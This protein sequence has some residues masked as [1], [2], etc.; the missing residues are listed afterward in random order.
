VL[1][2]KVRAKH[3]PPA[4]T[5]MAPVRRG[6]V[7]EFDN[8]P[9]LAQ[10]LGL[11]LPE[12]LWFADVKGLQ[13]RAAAGKL[14]HYRYLWRTGRSGR[15]RLLEAPK[16]R[17]RQIQRTLLDGVLAPIG[18]SPAVHGFV[19]GRS[20]VTAARAHLGSAVLI[21]L[22][23]ASFFSS[24]GA[25]RVYGVFRSAG[26]PQPVAHL[27]TGLCTTRT[28]VSV[29][30]SMPPAENGLWQRGLLRQAHLPQGAPT[31]PALA[32]LVV[33]RLD[34]R[35]AGY[36]QACGATYTRY[37]DD[38][39]F[40]VAP[41]VPVGP[42]RMIAGISAII[43]SEQLRVQP[44]K[45]RVQR[46]HQRQTVTGIVVNDRPNLPREDFDQLKALLHNAVRFGPE[47]QN[48]AGVADF[49]AHLL[50][51]IAWVNQLSPARADRLRRSFD[52][53]S[54]R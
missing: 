36:A 2:A 38:L 8:E 42:D 37:A 52:Q 18:L 46:A 27:L 1:T 45:T 10:W 35:L 4:P 48:R 17:L 51:R 29:L 47:S 22:D 3:I 44:A 34:R 20:A 25:A 19:P 49:R 33:A 14:H 6:P 13:R 31:S 12:L 9:D 30:T 21:S 26:Y 53:I 54:W 5:Q 50:G 41:G 32:N 43:D 39:V 11:E 15:P 24:L 40:S 28:P 23:L 16:P 7:P